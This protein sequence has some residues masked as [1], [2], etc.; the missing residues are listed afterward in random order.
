MC[1]PGWPQ[2]YATICANTI[3]LATWLK[4][5]PVQAWSKLFNA[6]WS[7]DQRVNEDAAHL[8]K[9][10]QYSRVLLT[11]TLSIL[12]PHSVDPSVANAAY[13]EMV[14]FVESRSPGLVQK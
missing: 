3:F 7:E 6:W 8:M 10:L 13:S 5:D 14:N 2:G 1:G 9:T 12:A 11:M 4:G